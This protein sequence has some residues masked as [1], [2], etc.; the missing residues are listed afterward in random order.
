MFFPLLFLFRDEDDSKGLVF[1][2][3]GYKSISPGTFDVF[4]G[5]TIQQAAAGTRHCLFLSLD[6]LVYAYGN[7][8]HGQ[9]GLGTF[10]D[11]MEQPRLIESLAGQCTNTD[12]AVLNIAL[13][14]NQNIAVLCVFPCREGG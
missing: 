6:G 11:C 3:E 10:R 7:N 13:K 2:W 14:T 8:Q 4:N 12:K 1:M 9:L 5:V